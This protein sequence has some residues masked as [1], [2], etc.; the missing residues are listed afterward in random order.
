MAFY[1]LR[2]VGQATTQVVKGPEPAPIGTGL[3]YN[4]IHPLYPQTS[5]EEL[6]FISGGRPRRWV[7]QTWTLQQW[8][9]HDFE[10][11]DQVSSCRISKVK[12]AALPG[13]GNKWHRVK[14][15][16]EVTS[17]GCA[18]FTQVLSCWLAVPGHNAHTNIPSTHHTPHVCRCREKRQTRLLVRVCA[19]SDLLLWTFREGLGDSLGNARTLPGG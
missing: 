13:R 15:M 1:C 10:G 4:A 16:G 12:R 9:L 2:P 3:E 5:P 7:K 17:L 11:A 8:R 14:E 18:L 19:L 6:A